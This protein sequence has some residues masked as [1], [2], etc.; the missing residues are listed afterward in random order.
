MLPLPMEGLEVLQPKE[1][2]AVALGSVLV[3]PGVNP[4][5][6]LNYQGLLADRARWLI[7]ENRD[8]VRPLGEKL[9]QAGVLPWEEE[10]QEVCLAVL[11]S[12]EARDHLESLGLDLPL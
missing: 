7:K 6:W 10:D 5:D 2:R 1:R 11:Q 4:K 3:K 9:F 12:P 8:N